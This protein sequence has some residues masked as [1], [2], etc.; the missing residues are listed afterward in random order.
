MV[1]FSEPKRR[2]IF[3]LLADGFVVEDHTA[4]AL[5][6]TRRG[7]DQFSIRAP[8]LH[9][10]WDVELCETFVAGWITFIHRKQ[11]FIPSYERF[12]CIYKLFDIH[13]HFQFRISGMSWPCLS[14]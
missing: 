8:G 13:F 2:A 14:M 12:R 5:T 7:D 10:L 9:R 6:E 1:S 4:N 11:T 3:L